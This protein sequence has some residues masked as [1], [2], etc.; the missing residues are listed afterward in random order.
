[1][2]QKQ[3]DIKIRPPPRK[4][5][6]FFFCDAWKKRIERRNVGGVSMR[7]RNGV[8]SRTGCVVNGQNDYGKQPMNTPRNVC[9]VGE[10][11]TCSVPA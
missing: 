2:L 6:H 4:S 5:E 8:P 3:M 7:S 10:N 1:M 11:P 9:L